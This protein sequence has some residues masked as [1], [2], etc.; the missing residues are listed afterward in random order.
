M[1]IHVHKWTLIH[2]HTHTQFVKSNYELKTDAICTYVLDPYYYSSHIG[3]Y[4]SKYFLI[5][6]FKIK[7]Q[8]TFLQNIHHL[9]QQC[10]CISNYLF[11]ITPF[12]NN[13]LILPQQYR[14][15]SQSTQQ[16]RTYYLANSSRQYYRQSEISNQR[17]IYRHTHPI[18]MTL[19]LTSKHTKLIKSR[20]SI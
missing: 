2:T 6:Y 11:I 4:Q 13:Q 8:F 15:W 20:R 3:L 16:L 14:L 7:P 12:T 5:I 17:Y 10:V 9:S 18:L 1:K 19:I